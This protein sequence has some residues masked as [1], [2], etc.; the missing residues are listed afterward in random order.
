MGNINN[1]RNYNTDSVTR[2]KRSGDVRVSKQQQSGTVPD[3]SS[4]SVVPDAKPNPGKLGET[5]VA[6]IPEANFTGTGE[7]LALLMTSMLT[8]TADVMVQSAATD[9]LLATKQ[10][11]NQQAEREKQI[12]EMRRKM[13]EAEKKTSNPV[14]KA[15]NKIFSGIGYVLGMAAL[16]FVTG[17][18]AGATSPLLAAAVYGSGKQIADGTFDFSLTKAM[19]TGVADTLVGMGVAQGEAQKIAQVAVGVGMALTVMGVIVAP[20]SIGDMAS[21]AASLAGAND[22][23][24][25]AIQTA[26]TIA[27]TIAIAIA[28]TVA[29]GGSA[30]AAMFAQLGARVGATLMRGAEIAKSAYGIAQ[31]GL[32]VANGG[33]GISVAINK[34][35]ASEFEAKVKETAAMLAQLAQLDQNNKEIIETFM[36]LRPEIMGYMSDIIKSAGDMGS[37]ISRNIA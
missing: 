7:D 10:R 26:V 2:Y 30:G 8:K 34:R 29:S 21:G 33:V 5:A 15:F 12:N 22:T 19:Q 16:G 35:D 17:L 6:D 20:D 9:T 11:N 24:T 28:M 36:G 31:G 3:T 14:L 37:N 25:M 4:L 32:S 1:E 13:A 23:A 18:T 27:T